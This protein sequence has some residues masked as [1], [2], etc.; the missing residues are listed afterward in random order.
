[1]WSDFGQFFSLEG[2][3]DHERTE[4]LHFTPW[5]DTVVL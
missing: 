3:G 1:M 2:S 4:Y 5:D